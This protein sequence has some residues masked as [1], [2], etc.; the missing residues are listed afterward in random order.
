[1]SLIAYEGGL[2]GGA[3]FK[4]A[5]LGVQAIEVC[6]SLRSISAFWIDD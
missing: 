5:A 2:G 1:M 3:D 6:T 4:A